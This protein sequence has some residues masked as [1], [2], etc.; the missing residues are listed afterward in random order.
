[1]AYLLIASGFAKAETSA[2]Q[3]I[4]VSPGTEHTWTFGNIPRN[5][6]VLL[7]MGLRR[8][9][10]RMAGYGYYA[11]VF[12][13]GKPLEAS[14]NRRESRVLNKPLSFHRRNGMEV[15]WSQGD[16]LWHTFF[17]PDFQTSTAGFDVKLSEDPYH[18][19]L[20][21]TDLVRPGEENTLTVRNLISSAS[22]VGKSIVATAEL[23]YEEP[24]Q[25]EQQRTEPF[26]LHEEL[27][28]TL[29]ENGGFVLVSGEKEIPFFSTYS[30]PDGGYNRLGESPLE[31][32]EEEWTI[33]QNT[34]NNNS[35]ETI[36]EG[37]FY[38]IHRKIT[39]QENRFLIEETVTNL[40][41][42][43]VG[44][45][46]SLHLGFE[47]LPFD[48]CRISGRASE[49]LNDVYSPENPTLFLPLQDSALGL[50]AEDDVLRNQSLL[51]Y[52][53][54]GNRAGFDNQ[55]FALDGGKS[56]TLQWS[57]YP[58]KSDNYFDFINT[59][60]REWGSNITIEAP[61]YFD[62][63][64]AMSTQS[65]EQ[66]QQILSVHNPKYLSFWEIAD[67]SLS[68]PEYPQ[69]DG[70]RINGFGTGIL[71]PVL[72][73]EVEI[74]REITQRLARIAP[75]MK[76]TLYN[77]SFFIAPE[78]PGDL[79]Y[80]DSWLI[81]EQG[82]RASSVYNSSTRVNYQ[83]VYPTLT[84]SYGKD[85]LKLMDFYLNNLG[86]GWL[87]WDESNGPGTTHESVVINSRISYRGTFNTWDGHTAQI[88]PQ[89]KQIERKFALLPLLTR[90]L[91]Q[92]VRD[93]V[94]DKGGI[95]YYNSA[96]AVRQRVDTPAFVE[97]QFTL[98]NCY[99]TH[100]NTPLAY[101]YGN[102]T[103]SD[104]RQRLQF[105]CLYARTHLTYPSN[106]VAR[107]YPFTPI[108]LQSGWVKG[109]ERIIT[110]ID[111]SFGWDGE[112]FQAT[113]YA[114]DEDG[115]EIQADAVSSGPDGLFDIEVPEG[116][117]VILE[118]ML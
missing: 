104:I 10:E 21:V 87:Y 89:T 37:N 52:D 9:N 23:S 16:G 4:A 12:W 73:E 27:T 76:V 28:V 75:E 95:V 33:R 50:V 44:I 62:N 82:E 13:N 84:N 18:T 100:L 85:Y 90:P 74:L 88:N 45:M 118:R 77:H 81:N 70:L 106:V 86:F 46:M 108:E 49:S 48:S 51:F 99:E 79:R 14:V 59:V 111:G 15:F 24:V 110:M 60:R 114:Y 64:R 83:S 101:G 71:H 94:E 98:T 53:A 17:S 102:P 116:G 105:G 34:L 78:E 91:F 96:A 112:S 36:A 5:Q 72:Q 107:C 38:R 63:Y 93:R 115:N 19:V 6:R 57:V 58:V 55:V 113:C 11:Q 92:E 25:S 8:D 67:T 32:G 39:Q 29:L 103:M 54:D 65:D 1:M 35:W 109:E 26:Q 3:E 66:L 47:G 2:V 61:L 69:W 97:T 30:Y 117:I 22:S 56:Y 80:Q 42:Q 41:D 68:H 20:D 40:T 43:P 31:G 7:R